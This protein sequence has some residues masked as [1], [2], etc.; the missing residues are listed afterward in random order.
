MAS[1]RRK[2]ETPFELSAF[3]GLPIRNVRVWLSA[4]TTILHL[5]A[6]D[7]NCPITDAKIEKVFHDGNVAGLLQVGL[8][9]F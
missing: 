6:M 8:T 5:L 9:G 4:L 3:Q 1:I 7:W 2:R